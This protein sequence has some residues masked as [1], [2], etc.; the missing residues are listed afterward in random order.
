M[1]SAGRRPSPPGE[2]V[3]VHREPPVLTR[4]RDPAQTR[5]HKEDNVNAAT[6]QNPPPPG[7]QVG[8]SSTGYH[9]L[10]PLDRPSEPAFPG[11]SS[12][13]PRKE[14]LESPRGALP[15]SCIRET[16]RHTLCQRK[17]QYRCPDR[18]GGARGGSRVL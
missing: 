15:T 5:H 8:T 3:T 18:V 11:S 9:R 1:E 13:F 12:S 6:T 10:T 17:V 7:G 2:R 14:E 4:S 16:G